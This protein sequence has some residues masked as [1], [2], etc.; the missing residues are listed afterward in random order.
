M[1]LL[2]FCVVMDWQTVWLHQFSKWISS[3]SSIVYVDPGSSITVHYVWLT[4]AFAMC[5]MAF[6]KYISIDKQLHSDVSVLICTGFIYSPASLSQ[7]QSQPHN[8]HDECSVHRDKPA[9]W[10]FIP[11]DAL[12]AHIPWIRGGL[13]EALWFAGTGRWWALPWAKVIIINW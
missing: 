9:I 6:Q 3:A 12:A 2:L 7:R 10:H 5:K 8:N 13:F 11:L 4:A 1:R